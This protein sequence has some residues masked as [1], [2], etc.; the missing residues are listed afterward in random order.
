MDDFAK[1][2]RMS[3]N[4]KTAEELYLLAKTNGLDFASRIRMLRQVFSLSLIE[5]KE[6]TVIADKLGVS[7]EDYQEKLIP[8]LKKVLE[9]EEDF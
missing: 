5:A 3:A 1:Y 6:I 9:D 7:L 8:G 4:G 2:M